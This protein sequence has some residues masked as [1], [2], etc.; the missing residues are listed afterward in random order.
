V[1]INAILKEYY[2]YLSSRCQHKLPCRHFI[3]LDK[4]IPYS[5]EINNSRSRCPKMSVSEGLPQRIGGGGFT[6]FYF[7]P[8]FKGFR[9][10]LHDLT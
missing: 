4:N 10:L 5:F 6:L 9:I 2:R 1:L 8:I 7:D 3:C